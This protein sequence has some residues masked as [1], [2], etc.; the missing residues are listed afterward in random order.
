MKTLVNKYFYRRE[1]SEAARIARVWELEDIKQLINRRNFYLLN[2]DREKELNELWVHEPENRA[3]AQYGTNWGFFVG[4]DEVRRGYLPRSEALPGYCCFM[5]LSTC[6]LHIAADGDTAYGLWYGLASEAYDVGA[7]ARG[8]HM[9]YRCFFDFKKEA[10]GWRIW[11]MF[12][13]LDNYAEVGF[14]QSQEPGD[15]I[16]DGHPVNPFRQ[17]LP[18]PSYL[19]NAYD[20]KWSWCAFPVVPAAHDSYDIRMSCSIEGFLNYKAGQM[21][22]QTIYERL[23]GDMQ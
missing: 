11:H 9:F 15:A 20:P 18:E 14:D 13:G 19:M 2:N 7:G 22:W 6:V 12:T 16:K 5:P 10:D 1:A 3:T 21:D 23:G 17:K 4:M 8:Y